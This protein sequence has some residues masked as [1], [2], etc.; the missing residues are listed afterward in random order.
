MLMT[1]LMP[2]LSRAFAPQPT[3]GVAWLEICSAMGTRY[4]KAPDTSDPSDKRAG[5]MN[6]CP[7]CRVHFDLPVLPPSPPLVP[8]F[9]ILSER[10]AL[11]YHAPTPLYSW[12][13]AHPRGPPAV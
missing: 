4:V 9:V 6:D 3:A 2:T 11:F 13:I 8:Q 7:Y 12:V 10:P 1:A 5:S